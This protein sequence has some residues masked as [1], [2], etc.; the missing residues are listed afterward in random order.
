[1]MR[2]ASPLVALALVAPSGASAQDPPPTFGADAQVVVLD[3]VVRDKKGKPVEDLD[4][5]EIT[6]FE[7]GRACEVLSFRLV[8]SMAKPQS[9]ATESGAARADASPGPVATPAA[10]PTR[11][12]LVVLVFD[13]LTPESAILARR[14]LST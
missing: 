5:K 8:R 14:A 3:L 11:P 9:A 6:V 7:D 2:L 1:M 4:T 12:S 10:T 13:R